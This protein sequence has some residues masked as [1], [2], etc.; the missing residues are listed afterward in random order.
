MPKDGDVGDGLQSRGDVEFDEVVV[1]GGAGAE[2]EAVTDFVA[3]GIERVRGAEAVR[4]ALH[5]FALSGEAVAALLNCYVESHATK[6]YASPSMR[7]TMPMMM[8]RSGAWA[9]RTTCRAE[10]PSSMT[11]TR[12]PTPAPTSPSMAMR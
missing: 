2:F 12:S 3:E 8:E 5:A 10:L 9:S 11:N 1:D 4:A 6:T 7:S